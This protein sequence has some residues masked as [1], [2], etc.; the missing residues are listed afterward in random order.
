MIEINGVRFYDE[1]GSCG[2]YP[3]LKTGATHFSP[4]GKRGLCIMWN[5]MH[6]RTRNIPARCHKLS[7]KA[8]TYPE[9]SKL[10]I[11]VNM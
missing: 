11:V 6:L 4:G 7:K 8:L 3:C 10:T 1:P 5:E 2:S 9:G